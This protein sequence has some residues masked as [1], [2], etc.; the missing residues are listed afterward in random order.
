MKIDAHADTRIDTGAT[1]RDRPR[2]QKLGRALVPRI[3]ARIR[4]GTLTV[5]DDTVAPPVTTVYGPGASAE[6]PDAKMTITDPRFYSA[7]ASGGRTGAAE[8][9]IE[10]YWSSED[11]ALVVE[12]LTA[13]LD[14]MMRIDG[15]LTRLAEPL[16]RLAYWLRRNTKVG[17]RRNIAAHYDLSNEFFAGFLDP[18]MT[19]SSAIF[20]D[21]AWGLQQAQEEKLD[22]ACRKL[23]LTSADHLLEIGTGWGSMAIHAASNYGCRVTTTTISEEQHKLA[24]RRVDELGLA[25][26]VEV[27]LADYRDLKGEYDKLVSIEMIEAVGWKFLEGYLRTCNQRL[28]TSGVFLLQ[29]IVLRDDHYNSAKK[30]EDFLKRYIFPGS[31]LP[32]ISAITGA[33]QRSTD[34]RVTHLEDIG[35]HYAR[36]LRCWR[37][38]FFAS[39]DRVRAQGFSDRFV[40]LWEFYLCYCEGVFAARHASC[41]QMLLAR[42][43]CRAAPFDPRASES[44]TSSGRDPRAVT[45]PVTRPNQSRDRAQP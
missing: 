37:D 5:T 20:A 6:A 30:R 42:P 21:P 24:I 29:S 27:L 16:N 25:D 9:F 15:P 14:A 32:S 35:P 18:T 10:G 41:V 7:L 31:F 40:R 4:A 1:R 38:N 11:P 33:M 23:E 34:F 26:R 17:S 28:S 39:I 36:T 13:N 2:F 22:R 12:T 19:Y 3:L 43:A 45:R 44:H 8:A